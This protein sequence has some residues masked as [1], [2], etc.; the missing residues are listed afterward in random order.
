VS[1]RLRILSGFLV[2]T[3]LLAAVAGFGMTRFAS[4]NTATKKVDTQPF[5]AMSQAEAFQSATYA[6][7][8]SAATMA[9]APATD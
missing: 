7:L 1:I 5:E 3:A 8:V 4:A 2:V 9:Y 6:V